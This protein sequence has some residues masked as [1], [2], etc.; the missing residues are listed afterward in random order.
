M[1][2]TINGKT[3]EFAS[4]LTVTDLLKELQLASQLVLVE[5]NLEIVERD[6]MAKTQV[7]EGDTIEVLKVVGGGS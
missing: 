3:R 4:P 7:T 2:V 5:R 1:I 6:D